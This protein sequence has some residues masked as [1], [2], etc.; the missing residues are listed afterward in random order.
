MPG[1]GTFNVIGLTPVPFDLGE[2]LVLVVL[3]RPGQTSHIAALSP[4]CRK[5]RC[6]AQN[7]VEALPKPKSRRGSNGYGASNSASR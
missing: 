6:W 3:K 7:L 4:E 2:T 5:A 1:P